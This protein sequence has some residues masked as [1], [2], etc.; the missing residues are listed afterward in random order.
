MMNVA[1][2]NENLAKRDKTKKYCKLCPSCELSVETCL[3]ILICPE[4]GRV[5]L[6]EE[7]IKLLENWLRSVETDPILVDCICEYARGRGDC[8]CMRS[9]G[10]IT[11]VIGSWGYLKTK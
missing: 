9:S 7:T 11:C 6:L 3:H 4:A 1:A 8:P 2:T 5:T 10:V